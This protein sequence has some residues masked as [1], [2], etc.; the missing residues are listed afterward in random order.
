[1]IVK[2]FNY[3]WSPG[4]PIPETINGIMEGISEGYTGSQPTILINSTWYTDSVHGEVK[5][6]IQKEGIKQVIL[7]SFADAYIPHSGFFEG[8]DVE[9]FEI[10]YY[11]GLGFYDFWACVF[12]ENHNRIPDYH[13]LKHESI[14]KPFMCLNRKHHEHRVRIVNELRSAGLTDKGIVTLAGT[15]LR[16]DEDFID[17]VSYAPEEGA[18]IPNDI[19]TLG[20]TNIWCSHF[21]NVVTETWWSINQVHFVSEKIYKPMVGLRPFLLWS[22]DMGV[23]WL[24]DRKFEL[25]HT[26]FQDITDLNLTN[27]ENMIPFLKIL[28]QQPKTYLEN[29]FV[30]LKEKLLYNRN[31]FD[32]YVQ[33]QNLD[34][35]IERMNQFLG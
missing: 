9:C 15:D 14:T 23:K 33:E 31:R 26:D 35:V 1:M 19:M 32:E 30:D 17:H 7:V 22:E 18:S 13:L 2:T 10:G 21:L 5:K 3:G 6:F 28:S 24:T 16:I 34:T 29:K 12:H 20:N 27:H 8:L 11:P 25:Y 4:L